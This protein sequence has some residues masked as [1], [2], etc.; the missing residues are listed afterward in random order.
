MVKHELVI[1]NKLGIHARP[2]SSIVKLAGKYKSN[3]LIEKDSIRA[4]AKSIMDLLILEADMGSKV[5]VIADGEDEEEAL[6]VIVELIESGF[7][8]VYKE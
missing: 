5:T 3:I 1:R 8:E 7:D 2:A 4:N 6:N